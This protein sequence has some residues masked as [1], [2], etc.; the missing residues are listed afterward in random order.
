VLP[1][2]WRWG[3]ALAAVL[4]LT[5]LTRPLGG[6]LLGR[7]VPTWGWWAPLRTVDLAVS[8]GRLWLA[9]EVMGAPIG[10]G[11]AVVAASASLLVKLAGL[12]PNGLGLSEWAVAALSSALAPV[13]T[14]TGAA[15]AL[16]D[17]AAE[18]VVLIVAGSISAW[19]LRK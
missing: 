10:Y 7:V 2:G 19:W 12:T 14:A 16:L 17:R 9:F 1:G 13:S 5:V 15:A 3:A 4:V 11:D 6:R 18:A 8:A